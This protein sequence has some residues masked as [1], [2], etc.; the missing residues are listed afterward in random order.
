VI[1]RSRWRAAAVA[2]AAIALVAAGSLPALAGSTTEPSPSPGSLTRHTYGTPGTDGSRDYLVY[3][4]GGKVKPGRPVVVYLHGCSQT[5]DDAAI[6]TRFMQPADREKFVVVYPEQRATPGS[7]AP[8]SD[9]NGIGCWNWFLPQDQARDQ[10]EPATI[11]A[12]TRQVVSATKADADRVYVEGASA[13]GAMADILGA[14]YPDVFAAVGVVAGCA[15][16]TCTDLTGQLTYDAMG[17]RHRA[18]PAI[19]IQGTLDVLNPYPQALGV[20]SQWLGVA[21]LTDDGALNNSVARS[22]AATENHIPN[23]TPAPGSG[24]PCVRNGQFPCAG[25]AIGFQG[26]YPY[27][28]DHFAGA[29]GSDLVQLWTVHGMAHGYPGG[30]PR[31]TFTDPLGPDVTTA[32]Y[33]FFLSHPRPG[34]RSAQH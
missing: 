13:G 26:S 8:L 30:D 29:G 21:D 32:A 23:G 10:G 20:V 4:P 3:L 14:T 11:A 17:T 24:D 6:G 19:V 15:Y 31:G 5:A 1:A 27:T 34:S 33:T 2:L 7:S 12:I 18:M 22:P 25:G 9:G 28:V 16:A